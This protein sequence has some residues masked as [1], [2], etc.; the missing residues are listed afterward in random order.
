MRI[1]GVVK[2]GDAGSPVV[3]R[4]VEGMI[5]IRCAGVLLDSDGVLVD[6]RQAIEAAWQQLAAEFSLNA[7]LL[8][9]ERAGLPT[10]DLLSRYLSG[11][12]LSDAVARLEDLEVAFAH[13]VVELPGVTDL[14][15]SL[16]NVPWAV[17][18]SASRRLAEIRW[19]AAGLPQPPAS[20]TADDVENGKPSPD[21]FLGA[22]ALLGVEPG[23]CVVFEDSASGGVSAR[24]SGAVVVAVGCQEWPFTPAA[25]VP[26]LTAVEA[27]TQGGQTVVAVRS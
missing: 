21:P 2:C 18:T 9:S 13:G 25:R 8:A 4:Y 3:L 16:E 15:A 20:I 24:R 17:V 19:R 7:G 6:S 11:A 22:A 23:D 12:V 14:L 1:E 26:D 10:R 27:H 5:E